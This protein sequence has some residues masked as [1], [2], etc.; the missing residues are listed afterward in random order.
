[1]LYCFEQAFTQHGKNQTATQPKDNQ[2][3][4]EEFE[5]THEAFFAFFQ[6]KYR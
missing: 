3:N 6:E 1:M 2:F 4:K 5:L